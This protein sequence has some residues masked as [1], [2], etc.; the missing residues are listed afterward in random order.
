MMSDV[1]HTQQPARHKVTRLVLLSLALVTVLSIIR[2][3]FAVP[4][5]QTEFLINQG[6]TLACVTPAHEGWTPMAGVPLRPPI[7]QVVW[8]GENTQ[9]Y[10]VA[11]E[12]GLFAW[13]V[14]HQKWSQLYSD[15]VFAVAVSGSTLLIGSRRGLLY[16][17]IDGSS[18]RARG[19]GLPESAIPLVI[20]IAPSDG[21]VIYVGTAQ[22]GVFRSNDGGQRFEP[23]NGG[24]P[25][26]VGAAPVTLVK[27][28]VIDPTNAEVAYA[29]TEVNGIYKTTDGGRWWTAANAGLPGLFPYRTYQPLLAFH[30]TQAATLYAVLGFPVHSHLIENKVYK[31]TDGGDRWFAIGDL[32]NDVVFSSL[33][34]MG[35]EP[36]ELVLGFEESV[37]RLKDGGQRVDGSLYWTPKPRPLRSSATINTDV[38]DIAVIEDDGTLNQNFD[39]HDRSI[40]CTPT[41]PLGYALAPIPPSLE[42]EL[43]SP[44]EL[45]DNAAVEVAIPFPFSYFGTTYN[46]VFVNSNGHLTF[47]GSDPNSRPNTQVTFSQ[48]RLGPP[49][50]AVFWE[51]FD[52]SAQGSVHVRVATNPNRLIVTWNNVRFKGTP[53]PDS[54][55]FQAVL[56]EGGRIRLNYGRVITTTRGLVGL[57]PGNS[58]SSPLILNLSRDLPQRIANQAVLE[59]FNG[60]GLDIQATARKFYETHADLYDQ[61]VVFGSGAFRT[62]LTGQVMALAFH[63]PVQNDVR[64]IGRPVGDIIG[65]PEAFGSQGRLQSFLNMNRVAFYPNDPTAEI[66]ATISPL[67][68]IGHE[69]AHRW[70]AYLLYDNNGTP[71]LNLLQLDFTHWNFFLNTDAS[72]MYGNRWRDNEDGSFTSVEATTRYSALDQYAMGLRPPADVKPFFFIGQAVDPGGRTRNSLPEVDVTVSGSRTEVMIEQIIA[73]NGPRQPAFGSSPTSLN[74]AY[75]LVIPEGTPI[76]PAEVEKVDRFRRAFESYFNQLT[77]QRAVVETRLSPGQADLVIE[78]ADLSSMVLNPGETAMVSLTIRNEGTSS[79]GL[80]LNE[81]RISA[82]GQIDTGDPVL[83]KIPTLSLGPGE[84]VALTDIPIHLPLTAGAGTQFVILIV[85]ADNA[86]RESNET[87]NQIVIP[88]TLSGGGLMLTPVGETEPNDRPNQAT[89]ITPDVVITAEFGSGRDVDF[90]SFNARAG[91]SLTVDLNAQSLSPRSSANTVVTVF[92]GSGIQLAENDDFAGSRDSFLQLTIPRTGQYFIRVSNVAPVLGGARPPYQAI[93]ILRSAGSAV[94]SEPNNDL[95]TATE[96]TPDV[97]ISGVLDP[98]G[99]QDYF[100]FTASAGQILSIDVDAQSLVEPSGADTLL[101]VFDAG[102]GVLGQNDDF[103]DSGDSFLQVTLPRTGRYFIRLRD[104]AGRGGPHFT[105]RVTVRLISVQQ[106]KQP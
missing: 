49:K 41:A 105:Y 91:Q 30:P 40:E 18:W 73:Q 33:T 48:F 78:R 81:I 95:M 104:V 88:V 66:A 36:P 43:G 70:L 29:S 58:R 17:P 68:A 85:D 63:A 106:L 86:A 87:N 93:V 16:G 53:L 1:S 102:G 11:A 6:K 89:L 75:I 7:H 44:V 103:A 51:D 65:G 42:I 56:L 13:S 77:G 2:T 15:A 46:S 47:G 57:S 45:A 4:G 80:V 82:D 59:F 35:N 79:A 28:L 12:N 37:I 99:D 96:I 34:V 98:T 39:L 26:S 14:A 61:L 101:T 90:Y 10:L 50:I 72:L 64:G 19:E 9:V 31:T 69:T 67:D 21:R 97:V 20:S 32:P 5:Q 54:N 76:V 71:S 74:Q 23:I 62:N 8:G 83:K 100:A 55:T 25:R 94:E 60:T 22:H 84:A 24:L 27:H 38:G 3:P 92:D 52:P